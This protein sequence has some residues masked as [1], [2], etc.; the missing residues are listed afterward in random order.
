MPKTELWVMRYGNMNMP[1]NI[2]YLE[3]NEVN[4]MFDWI[5]IW[6]A[7]EPRFTV[8]HAG[9]REDGGRRS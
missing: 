1:K 9:E 7:R 4:P 5:W 8:S 3:K 6:E 2:A